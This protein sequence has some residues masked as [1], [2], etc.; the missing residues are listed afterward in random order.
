MG[1]HPY[2]PHFIEKHWSKDV[3]SVYLKNGFFM[4]RFQHAMDVQQILSCIHTFEGRAIIIKKWSKNVVLQREDFD[5]L[6]L[7]IRVYD[8]PMHCR[9]S[10]SISKVCSIFST[11]IYMDD[12]SLHQDKSQFVRVIV[13]ADV[14]KELPENLVVDIHG[15]DCAVFIEYEWKPAICSLCKRVDHVAARCPQRVLEQ[16]KPKKQML[17]KWIVK[18]KRKMVEF[19]D[20]QQVSVELLV[21][22]IQSSQVVTHNSFALLD[23]VVVEEIGEGEDHVNQVDLPQGEIDNMIKQ[24]TIPVVV[25]QVTIIMESIDTRVISEGDTH[26]ME[27]GASVPVENSTDADSNTSHIT[28]K[29]T[30]KKMEATETLVTPFQSEGGI[31]KKSRYRAVLASDRVTRSHRGK[32]AFVSISRRIKNSWDWVHNYDAHDYSRI[33]V[34]W[35]PILFDVQNF[36]EHYSTIATGPWMALGDWNAIRFYSDKKGGKKVPQRILNDFNDCLHKAGLSEVHPTNGEWSWCNRHVFSRRIF[37]KLD[38]VFLNE[39]WIDSL[40]S[41]KVLY[42]SA[43]CSNH[44]GIPIHISKEF[45]VGPKPFKMLMVCCLQGYVQPLVKKAWNNEIS[46]NPIHLELL[47]DPSENNFQVEQEAKLGYQAVV[48]DQEVLV[49]QKSRILWRKDTDRCTS[50][51]YNKMKQHRNFNAITL[52]ENDSG[53]TTEDMGHIRTWF[54]DFYKK[55]FEKRDASLQEFDLP[56]KQLSVEE[57]EGL[58]GL[59]SEEEIKGVVMGFNPDKLPGPDGFPARFYQTFWSVV[60]KEVVAAVQYFLSSSGMPM[61]VSSCFLT[62]I[63]KVGNAKEM[64]DFRPIALCNLLYKVITKIMANR[65]ARVLNSLIGPEQSAFVQGRKIQDTLILAHEMVRDF[66]G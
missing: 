16:A 25:E 65:L 48:V 18:Q 19:E 37:V 38:R 34:G 63:P 13:E 35:N 61:G 55:L 45:A 11:P 2:Y 15:E 66:K 31:S 1:K 33:W 50:Y 9:N 30:D 46:G 40:P 20:A 42:T 43:T 17:D 32:C 53:Q 54:V 60:G 26:I 8:L 10:T 27:V 49:S 4:V 36:L 3:T 7:W 51:F 21:R 5:M 64:G 44:Y 12:P 14:R 41:T 28:A 6:P 52:V 47:R 58:D 62:L 39:R 22:P 23:Q 29:A 24:D 56:V 57:V 59:V